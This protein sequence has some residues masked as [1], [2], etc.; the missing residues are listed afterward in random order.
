M[1]P[2][3]PNVGVKGRFQ[4]GTLDS[5]AV[6]LFHLAPEVSKKLSYAV[7]VDPTNVHDLD[8]PLDCGRSSKI[9]P[10]HGI[11]LLFGMRR[12]D[13]DRLFMHHSFLGPGPVWYL[14]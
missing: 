12:L 4:R 7:L 2:E 3:D 6:W 11:Q 9:E 5:I 13:G 1:P 10:A 8:V 14:V